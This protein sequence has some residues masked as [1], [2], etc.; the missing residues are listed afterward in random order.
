MT[1]FSIAASSYGYLVILHRMK[2]LNL[3]KENV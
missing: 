1:L 2:I 3:E